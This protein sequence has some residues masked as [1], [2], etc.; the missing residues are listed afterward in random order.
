M[1]IIYKDMP[2][3]IKGFSALD[4]NGDP[5][6]VLNSRLARKQNIYT[7]LHEKEH[8]NDYGAPHDV[9]RLEAIRHK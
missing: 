4:C 2:C 1:R 8:A 5:V 9:N 3:N 7:Y 6:V